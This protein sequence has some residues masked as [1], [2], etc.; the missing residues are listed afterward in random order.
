MNAAE[1]MRRDWNMRARRDAFYYIAS[2]RRGWDTQEFFASGK[3]DY[4][5]LVAPVLTR[6]NFS[7]HR[8]TMLELGCGAGRMTRSF[9]SR[10]HHVL[11][12]DISSEM[13]DRARNLLRGVD[14]IAWVQG[15]GVDL[16]NVGAEST[17]FVFSYLV[18]QHLPDIALA[19]SYVRE[20]L[21][22]LRPDG[23]CLFQF[24]GA[25]RAYM[26]YRGRLAWGM[27][28]ALWSLRAGGL[29]RG[30]ARLAGLDPEMVGKSWHGVSVLASEISDIVRNAGGMVLDVWGEDTPMAWCCA[31]KTGSGAR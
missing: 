18:L 10:F 16:Q 25:K 22:V 23:L 1:A 13:I 26:N 19:A 30:F 9:A 27:A 6:F 21:R 3:V 15:N 4:E 2:W 12:F 20:M 5:R 14:N 11:G 8:K 24:N 29:G 31:R 28:D 17:E 7:P